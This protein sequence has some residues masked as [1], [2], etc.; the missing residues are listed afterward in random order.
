MNANEFQKHLENDIIPFWNKMADYEKGGFYG[1]AN[2]D[3]KP[4]K[5]SVKG[6]ILN[7]R[8]LWFYASSYLLLKKPELPE[9]ADNA[10]KF[11]SERFYD[12]RYGGVF[13][14]VQADG[15]PEDTMKQ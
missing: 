1:Y 2:S 13:R 8:I 12:S 6:C 7:S 11:L 3:G 10:Y 15:T 9:K 4:D 14:S 5:N